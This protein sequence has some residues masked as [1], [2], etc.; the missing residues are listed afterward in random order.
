MDVFV[1]FFIV[2]NVRDLKVVRYVYDEVEVNVRVLSVLGRKAE[3]YGGFLFFLMFYKILEE[4]R[5]SIC[6]KVFKENWN[7]EVVLKEFK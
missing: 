6:N 4:I 1:N 5:L 7:F 3:E 2:E